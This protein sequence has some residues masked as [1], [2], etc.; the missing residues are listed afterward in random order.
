MTYLWLPKAVPFHP[1]MQK[2]GSKSLWGWHYFPT[3]N[4]CFAHFGWE[5]IRKSQ[6]EKAVSFIRLK[7]QLGRKSKQCPCPSQ[8]LPFTTTLTKWTTQVFKFLPAENSFRA[9]SSPSQMFSVEN[10][11]SI[12]FEQKAHDFEESMAV[13]KCTPIAG[14]AATNPKIVKKKKKKKQ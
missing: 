7:H 4:P 11:C 12:D 14:K 10:F 8:T 5:Q 6:S 13:S 3:F 2:V 9:R 1:A